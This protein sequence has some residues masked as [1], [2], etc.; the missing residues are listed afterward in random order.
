MTDLSDRRGIEHCLDTETTGL[1]HKNGDRMVEIGI[2]ELD[3]LMPTGR[4]FHVYIN[5]QRD[6]PH[7]AVQV[8][9]LTNDFL[10]D[11]PRFGQIADDF[12]E[13]IGNAPLVI[14]NASFDIGFLNMEL[15]KAGYPPLTNEVVDTLR[16]ARQQ[17]PGK[18]STLD[19]LA[20]R[21][22]VD[23]SGRADSGLHGALIDAD[24]LAGVYLHLCGGPER[25]LKLTEGVSE[26]EIASPVLVTNNR[27]VRPAR[28]IG[29]PSEEELA[30]HST[31]LNSVKDALW[32]SSP[33]IAP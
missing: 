32:N 26:V 31:F 20:D 10:R 23:N 18:R 15:V 21:F 12:L 11:K 9:G 5:P 14:H 4:H 25:R 27:P 24:I 1:S 19:A 28:S 29:G 22:G 33:S 6:V 7:D 16:M 13:F 3:D 8:H 2:I 30:A 17:F